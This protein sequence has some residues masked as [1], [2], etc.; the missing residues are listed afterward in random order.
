MNKTESSFALEFKELQRKFQGE[1]QEKKP[2]GRRTEFAQ[3]KSAMSKIKPLD[4][5]PWWDRTKNV[6]V[7]VKHGKANHA[8]EEV[9]SEE[10][11][12]EVI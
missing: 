4:C 10:E 11:E 9:F 3:M 6:N 7:N 8:D 5:K 12:V 2:K 1:P